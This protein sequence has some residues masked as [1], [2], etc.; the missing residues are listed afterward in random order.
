MLVAG[1]AL[2]VPVES[3]RREAA[4]ANWPETE[5][6]EDQ[7]VAKLDL[8]LHTAAG[9]QAVG[10]VH[11]GDAEVE[12][13]MRRHQPLEAILWSRTGKQAPLQRL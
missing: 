7:P 9:R 12:D 10:A 1:D 11:Q 6:G 8:A 3:E 4:A 5:D 2:D 13:P